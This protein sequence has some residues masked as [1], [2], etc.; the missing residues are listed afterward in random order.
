MNIVTS[1]E[2]KLASNTERKERIRAQSFFSIGINTTIVAWQ[3]VLLQFLIFLFPFSNIILVCLCNPIQH[4][5]LI[6]QH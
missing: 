4:N 6:V 5:T 1:E 3:K 2:E